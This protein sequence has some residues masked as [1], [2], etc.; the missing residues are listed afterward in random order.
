[1]K[2]RFNRYGITLFASIM[3][4]LMIPIDVKAEGNA[5]HCYPTE[6]QIEAYK[7]ECLRRSRNREK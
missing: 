5:S 2:K 4:C 3:L 1:M 6:S 7:A